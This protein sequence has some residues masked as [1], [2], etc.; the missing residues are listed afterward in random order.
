MM[1]TSR[2]EKAAERNPADHCR[3]NEPK[4]SVNSGIDSHVNLHGRP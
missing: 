1:A 4:L 2:G 3:E